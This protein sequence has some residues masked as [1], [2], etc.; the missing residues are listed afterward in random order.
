MA[1]EYAIPSTIDSVI[2]TSLAD[3]SPTLTDNA[4]NRNV[5]LST[6]K[7]Y[8][9]MIDGG[10]T[11]V[12]SLIKTDQNNGGFYLG[13]GNLN[14]NQDDTETLVEYRYQNLYEPIQLTRDEERQN[15]GDKHRIINLMEDK[16]QRSEL[17]ISKRLEQSLSTSVAGSNNLINLETLVATGTLGTVAGGTDTFWQATVTAS[18]SFA[19]QGRSD[20]TTAFYAVA[21][22]ADS[23]T[24]THLVTNKTIFQYYENTL[25]PTERHQSAE[26]TVN[27]GARNL[28]FKG[29]PIIYGNFIGS[30]LMFGLNMNYN[31]L[32]VDTETDFATTQWLMP[33]NQTVKVAFVLW[34]GNHVTSNR[35]RNFKLTG[36]T[37]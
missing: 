1:N 31:D 7:P 29:V 10:S 22:S 19:A 15:S 6:L 33:V 11:I 21:S 27:S 12:Y 8:K 3:Y 5:L 35:R 25:L 16:I 18:G 30:G 37:A 2:A 20:M 14:T 4:Y 13:A 36:I 23:D 28:T 26:L 17:A 9:R 34:R 32:C 24:P